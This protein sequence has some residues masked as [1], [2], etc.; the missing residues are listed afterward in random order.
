MVRIE[1]AGR[2]GRQ[3]H[4]FDMSALWVYGFGT[5][6]KIGSADEGGLDGY[7]RNRGIGE[8]NSCVEEKSAGSF[9]ETRDANR[10]GRIGREAGR[11]KKRKTVVG[12]NCI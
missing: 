9:G 2:S 4:T 7:G 3:V 11:G 12:L 8:K 5:D 1:I 6:I 10:V